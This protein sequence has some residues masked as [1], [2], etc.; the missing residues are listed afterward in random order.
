LEKFKE[1]QL[2]AIKEKNEQIQELLDNL[3][4]SETLFEP[5]GH[6]LET[7]ETILV[8]DPSEIKVERYLTKEERA[9]LEVE[10]KRQEERDA[11]LKGDNVGQRGLKAMMGGTELNLKKDKGNLDQE[12]VREDWMNK[13]VEDMTDEEKTKF[14]EFE[15]K[16][17]EFKEK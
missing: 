16:E 1:D 2:F 11:A 10:R 3:K 17:K 14:K 4:Q 15:Q 8:V 6:H 13:P 7:P 9:A 5:K 12:L